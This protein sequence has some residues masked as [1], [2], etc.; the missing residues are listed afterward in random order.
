MSLRQQNYLPHSNKSTDNKTAYISK[1]PQGTSCDWAEQTSS[2]LELELRWVVWTYK[3]IYKCSNEYL[4][5]WLWFYTNVH[6]ID[7]LN[8]YMN[9][10]LNLHM[11]IKEKVHLL[12]MFKW[13]YGQISWGCILTKSYVTFLWS[14]KSLSWP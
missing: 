5:K 7:H 11:I 9:V 14:I 8:L 4:L 10:H 3:W 6:L 1:W 13:S 2:L 12:H